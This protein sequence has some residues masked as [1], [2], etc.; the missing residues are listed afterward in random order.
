MP[1]IP[2]LCFT[3]LPVGRGNK[4][5]TMKENILHLL[6]RAESERNHPMSLSRYYLVLRQGLPLLPEET[7][8]PV[9]IDRL[10][11]IW[12]CTPRYAKS[13]LRR[14]EKED[15]IRW[16]PGRGRGHVSRLAFRV[17]P[18]GP[19]IREALE[20]AAAGGWKE[21]RQLL[22]ESGRMTEAEKAALAEELFAPL[23]AGGRSPREGAGEPPPDV[24]RLPS[25]RAVGALD[26]LYANRRTEMHMA[27]QVYDTMVRFD[28][29]SPEGIVP[30]LAVGWTAQEDASRWMFFLNKGV[31]FHDGT[32]LTPEQAAASLE[33]L[34]LAGETSPYGWIGR[35]ILQIATSYA[36]M[37][38]V[39]L[40]G[41]HH[42][43]ALWLGA[44]GA[45]VIR[46]T[47]A[48][49]GDGRSAHPAGTGPFRP[50]PL[51]DRLFR[52]EAHRDYFRGRTFLDGVELWVLPELYENR[53][54]DAVLEANGANFLHYR[55][56]RGIAEGWGKVEESDLGCK[57]LSLNASES[58]PLRDPALRRRLAEGIDRDRLIRETGG[59]R[60]HPARRL[61][62]AGPGEEREP[63]EGVAGA[64][65]AEPD[66]SPP[67]RTLK[68][69]TYPGAGNEKDA[70]WLCRSW[71]TQGLQV[72]P[73]F[74]PYEVLITPEGVSEADLVLFEQPYAGHPEVAYM[75]AFDSSFS[76]L[77]RHC[78]Q[79]LRSEWE[80]V[81]QLCLRNPEP[82]ERLRLLE[83]YE[84]SLLRGH[85]AV[86]LY[87]SLQTAY[88][89][90]EWQ[91]VGLSPY[92]WVDYRQLW[93]KP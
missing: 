17:S 8:S 10:S 71:Q 91:K 92:G 59:N 90:P 52:L 43:F 82:A 67:V 32:L 42:A 28:P 81:R 5:C 31:R 19:L 38:E 49:E 21:L 56:A 64:S 54:A 69:H 12:S 75:S 11:E 46:P 48:H 55:Y 37:V 7:E 1:G 66:A 62:R 76:P 88:F 85:V 87:R 6:W 50:R 86:P 57:A 18:Y 14:M 40:S 44:L 47:P 35:D 51:T 53:R 22:G 39:R 70:E 41:T 33:R 27:S 29:A 23:Q 45:S 30:H 4:K 15:W 89:P 24:L 36:G 83:R 34:R 72:E 77:N 73:V 93:L 3:I 13:L 63:P 26:P 80:R 78:G 16:V 74:R 58:G 65:P 79:P 61:F 68:L 9:T 20:A 25:Y 60:H 84:A 2:E